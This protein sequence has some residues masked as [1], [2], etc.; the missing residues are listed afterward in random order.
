[1]DDIFE[2]YLEQGLE[3]WVILLADANFQVPT[4]QYCKQYKI[5]HDI[6]MRVLYDGDQVT[7]IYG[8]K[9]TSIVTNEEGV[10]VFE[11]HSDS[12]Q[13]ILDAVVQ[14]LNTG[15]GQCTHDQTCK[16]MAKCLPTPAQTAYICAEFCTEG[17]DSTCPDGQKCYTYGPELDGYSACFKESLIP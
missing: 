1:M 15:P 14:E 9:E 7:E 2:P 13:T 16:G 3:A 5:G 6:Q 17:D 11:G 10:I 12:A 8:Q 4:A